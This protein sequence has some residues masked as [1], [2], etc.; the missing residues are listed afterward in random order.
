[1][2]NWKSYRGGNKESPLVGWYAI[3]QMDGKPCLF[4]ISV[5]SPNPVGAGGV[6]IYDRPTSKLYALF[7]AN[8]GRKA[9]SDDDE[10]WEGYAF[11]DVPLF[12][13]NFNTFREAAMEA[14]RQV[15]ENPDDVP[16][17]DEG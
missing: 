13:N 16:E 7:K 6:T 1:M 9:A 11:D 10:T 8:N 17:E 5:Q 4:S 2:L 3:A 15:G 14:A 12:I